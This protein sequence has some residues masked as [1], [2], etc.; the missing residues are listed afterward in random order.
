MV[1]QIGSFHCPQIAQERW[2]LTGIMMDSGEDELPHQFGEFLVY[3]AVAF[4]GF[5]PDA[6]HEKL[7]RR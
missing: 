1:P 7:S 4:A 2:I 6:V 5:F 3:N